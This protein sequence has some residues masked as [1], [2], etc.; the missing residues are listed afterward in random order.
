MSERETEARTWREAQALQQ[1]LER[2]EQALGVELQAAESAASRW[3]QRW[4]ELGQA[5][6]EP[7]APV[8]NPV[9]ALEQA[10]QR[11]A[12]A[13]E[14]SQALVG[15]NTPWSS[16]ARPPVFPSTPSAAPGNRP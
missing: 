13:Q 4:R 7:L 1:R 9:A 5:D 8:D 6:G 14:R 2:D 10:E 11:L 15:A 12:L 16:R 3:Q